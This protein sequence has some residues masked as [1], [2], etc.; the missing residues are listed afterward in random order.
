MDA[1]QIEEGAA[2]RD[3]GIASALANEDAEWRARYREAALACLL[4][5]GSLGQ[6]SLY[7]SSEDVRKIVEMTGGVGE[8]HHPNVWSAAFAS[9]LRH[10]Q[11]DYAVVESG[12]HRATMARARR[13]RIVIYRME[14]KETQP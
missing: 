13:R 10:L 8:P 2:L 12:S 5:G 14:P 7:F 1:A 4:P 3:A 11:R 6:T 9:L